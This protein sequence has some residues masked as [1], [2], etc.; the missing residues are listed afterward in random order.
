MP[1]IDGSDR[2]LLLLEEQLARLGKDRRAGQVGSDPV[3][4]GTSAPLDRTRRLAGNKAVGEEELQRT[5]VRNILL[6]QFGDQIGGDAAFDDLSARVFR[7]MSDNEEGR[8]LIDRA[9]DQLTRR[10]A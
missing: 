7:M 2:V 3:A 9:L 8:A 1:R 10:S 5:M 4:G 6:D